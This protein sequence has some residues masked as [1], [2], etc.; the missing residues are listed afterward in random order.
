MQEPGPQLRVSPPRSRDAGGPTGRAC[1]ETRGLSPEP[2]SGVPLPP[3]DVSVGHRT[4]SVG[5]HG[6]SSPREA[7]RAALGRRP[8]RAIDG[9]DG[10]GAS[11]LYRGRA[12]TAARERLATTLSTISWV[13]PAG[14]GWMRWRDAGPSFRFPAAPTARG[15][16][17]DDGKVLTTAGAR[18]NAEE[19]GSR[20]SRARARRRRR[21][22]GPVDRRACSGQGMPTLALSW[23]WPNL[24]GAAGPE[25]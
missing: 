20:P 17:R 7:V 24:A 3:E 6:R 15:R 19:G 18:W 23:A 13:L 9:S 1:P 8:V 5:R 2:R 10:G 14:A 11:G 16:F 21:G 22:R 25:P 12:R 4:R